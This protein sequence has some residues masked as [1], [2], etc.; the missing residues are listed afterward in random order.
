MSESFTT[1]PVLPN[2]NSVI[3]P[4]V[5]P[6]KKHKVIWIVLGSI[7]GLF[8]LCMLISLLTP[9]KDGNELSEKSTQVNTALA[10]SPTKTFTLEPTIIPTKTPDPNLVKPGTYLVGTEIKA[11]VYKGEEKGC[12]WERLKDLSGTF[13]SIIANGNSKGQF[14]VEVKAGD[15][16]FSTD[17][18]VTLIDLDS[19]EPISFPNSISAGEYIVNKDIQPGIYKGSNEGCYWERVKDLFGGFDGIISNGSSD[20]QF[21]VRVKDTDKAINTDCDLSLVDLS[22]GHVGEFPQKIEP[23]LYLIGVDIEPGTYKGETEGCYWERLKDVDGGFGSIISN[24]NSDGQ[25]YVKVG[26]SDFALSTD[27]VLERTGD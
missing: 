3:P 15:T 12:Y 17:C 5:P 23:G 24:G 1:P 18:S 7:A 20:G 26:E 8:F 9:D 25:F 6:K 10:N 22:I 13:E 14:Y 19:T 4:S 21:Y 2:Q 11:G 16:A 27:C